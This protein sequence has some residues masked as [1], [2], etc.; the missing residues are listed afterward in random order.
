MADKFYL[1]IQGRVAGPYLPEEINSLFGC[2]SA[3]VLA[4]SEA[5]YAGGRP[6]WRSIAAIAPLAGCLRR[7]APAGRGP[8]AAR[9][10]PLCVLSTDDD[11]GI[12]ALLWS[13][14][15]DAGHNVDFAKDGE[16]VFRR[17]A[18][19]RYDLVILDVN[20]PKLNGYKVSEMLHDKL[21]NPPKVIIF[22][23]REIE[24]ER[25]Q[26]VCSGADAI[27]NKGTGNGKLLETIEG[28]FAERAAT[29]ADTEPVYAPEPQPPGIEELHPEGLAPG[30]PADVPVPAPALAPFA[31]AGRAEIPAPAAGALEAALG[32]ASDAVKAAVEA[33]GEEARAALARLSV[34]SGAVKTDLM[35][36]RRL[37]GHLELAYTQLEGQFEKQA[38]RAAE[39]NKSAA[40]RLA[41]EWRS[42][43]TFTALATLLLLV[44]VLAAILLAGG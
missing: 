9:K 5:E 34:E 32:R 28:L 30:G 6:P 35:D 7:P 42:L 17:L 19:K 14:L 39:A 21:P 29:P 8:A 41:A 13:L 3:D 12:R 15:N 18:E 37:L 1:Y 20:M 27:L 33:R 16:E 31:D 36:I 22:T 4:S 40:E 38:A 43:K 23:G 26:F 10:A 44:T 2:L 25:L 24:K 11:S